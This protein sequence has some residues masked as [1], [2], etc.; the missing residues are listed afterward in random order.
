MICSQCGV[1]SEDISFLIC[2]DC[3]IVVCY[4]CLKKCLNKCPNE[5]CSSEDF[6]QLDLDF[7]FFREFNRIKKGGFG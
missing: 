5:F 7:I 1:N 3:S 2:K 6:Q 4:E